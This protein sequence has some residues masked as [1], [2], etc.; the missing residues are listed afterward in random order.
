MLIANG[1]MLRYMPHANKIEIKLPSTLETIRSTAEPIS[2]R[3]TDVDELELMSVLNVVR[4]IFERTV[5][6]RRDEGGHKVSL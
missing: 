5:E 1:Y 4:L 3:R 6:E 2:N